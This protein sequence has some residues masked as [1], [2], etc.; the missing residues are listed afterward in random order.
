MFF[1][2]CAFFPSLISNTSI[3]SINF[4]ANLNAQNAGNGISGLH[5]F[6][7]FL[8]EY[9]P[10][11]RGLQPFLSLSNGKSPTGK[12]LKKAL[13]SIPKKPYKMSVYILNLYF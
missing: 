1:I 4:R 5:N 3:L 9:A 10:R 6:T 7:N 8:G 13:T 11:P 2:F 12:S